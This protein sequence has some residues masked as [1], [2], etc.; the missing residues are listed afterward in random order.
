MKV[1]KT[2]NKKKRWKDEVCWVLM[3]FLWMCFLGS[4]IKNVAYCTHHIRQMFFHLSHFLRAPKFY[5][6]YIFVSHCMSR[7]K[8]VTDENFDSQNKM[9]RKKCSYAHIFHASYFFCFFVYVISFLRHKKQMW[10]IKEILMR[11]SHFFHV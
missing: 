8:N 4:R 7:Q 6:S 1:K 10:R 5:A 2:Y 11:V 3:F 9:R